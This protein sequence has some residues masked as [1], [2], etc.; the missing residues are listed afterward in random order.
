MNCVIHKLCEELA[1]LI[2]HETIMYLGGHLFQT[3]ITA[4]VNTK[5][6]KKRHE[7]ARRMKIIEEYLC[8]TLN[9]T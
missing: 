4:Y 1:K 3:K 2:F 9:F 8:H 7:M 6:R 5:Q